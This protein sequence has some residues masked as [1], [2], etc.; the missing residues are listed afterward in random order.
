MI[1]A[2]SIGGTRKWPPGNGSTEGIHGHREEQKEK[3]RGKRGVWAKGKQF[4]DKVEH[5]ALTQST[6]PL[7]SGELK[8]RGLGRMPGGGRILLRRK[9]V[10]SRFVCGRDS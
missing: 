4:K 3:G 2:E 9:V 1:F 5:N 7:R 8:I 6:G 10:G